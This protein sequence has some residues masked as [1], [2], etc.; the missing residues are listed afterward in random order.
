[1][2]VQTQ[3]L[4]APGCQW[5]NLYEL[6][7]TH[8]YGQV[9]KYC[10]CRAVQTKCVIIEVSTIVSQ[11]YTLTFKNVLVLIQSHTIYSFTQFSE[12]NK[13]WLTRNCQR[14]LFTRA[15]YIDYPMCDHVNDLSDCK[16]KFFIILLIYLLNT[17]R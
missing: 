17:F 8:L 15:Q 7:V 16:D 10:R 4:T 6:N 1:M 13:I 9:T 3:M 11:V 5:M 12:F 14:Y 2:A